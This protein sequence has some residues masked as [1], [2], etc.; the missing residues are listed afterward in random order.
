MFDDIFWLLNPEFL[1]RRVFVA[2]LE[3]GGCMLALDA[4]GIVAWRSN[5]G[6]TPR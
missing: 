6:G 5:G 4:P 3:L 2:G 1:I